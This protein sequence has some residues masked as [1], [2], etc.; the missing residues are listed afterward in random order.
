MNA[1]EFWLCEISRVFGNVLAY[2]Y[3][4]FLKMCFTWKK[5]NLYFYSTFWCVDVKNKNK[6]EKKII[7]MCFEIKNITHYNTKHHKLCPNLY[8]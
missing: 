5:L 7:L 2:A 8:L 6:S 4:C 1:V 3:E